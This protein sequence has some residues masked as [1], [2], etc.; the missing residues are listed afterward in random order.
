MNQIT[1]ESLEFMQEAKE[2]F[3]NNT[4][5]TTYRDDKEEFIALRSGMFDDCIMIYEL[6]SQVGNFVQQLPRQHKVTLDYD[7]HERLKKTE[8]A[9]NLSASI[10]RKIADLT[11]NDSDIHYYCLNTLEELHK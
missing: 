4:D 3:E 1:K 7:E 9:V 2:A 6:G 11:D 10:L 8:K 5:L